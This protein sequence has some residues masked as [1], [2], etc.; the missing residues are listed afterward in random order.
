MILIPEDEWHLDFA[1]PQLYCTTKDGKCTPMEYETP[2]Q[3]RVELSKAVESDPRPSYIIDPRI[4]VK[5][6]KP[7]VNAIDIKG[8]LYLDILK[9]FDHF[10]SLYFYK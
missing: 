2:K 6:L 9:Q 1:T 5:Y 7:G 3:S 10:S 4:Q 8:I